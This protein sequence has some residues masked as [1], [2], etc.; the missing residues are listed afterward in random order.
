MLYTY[1]YTDLEKTLFVSKWN[2][3]YNG[4]YREKVQ[5]KIY[6]VIRWYAIDI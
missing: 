2:V 6:G 3:Y 4:I 1:G 5:I